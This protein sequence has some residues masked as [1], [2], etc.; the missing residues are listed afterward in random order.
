MSKLSSII[1]WVIHTEVP[2]LM[3]VVLLGVYDVATVLKLTFVNKRKTDNSLKIQSID[4]ELSILKTGTHL[5]K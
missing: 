5:L 4:L 3:L 1:L 2:I